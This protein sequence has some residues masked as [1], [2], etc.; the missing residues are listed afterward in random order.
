MAKTTALSRLHQGQA[1]TTPIGMGRMT[2]IIHTT[3]RNIKYES[4]SSE[5]H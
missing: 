5:S 2:Q 1:S 4:Y 3:V